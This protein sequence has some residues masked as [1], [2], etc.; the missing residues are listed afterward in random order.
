MQHDALRIGVIGVGGMGT[1]HART[2]AGLAGVELAAVADPYAPNVER[3]VAEFGCA[4]SSD[5]MALATDASLDAV[6]IASPDETHPELA[7]AAL[8]AGQWVL[9]E[10]PLATNL[11]DARRV[12]D[13]EI[14]VGSRRI[15]MGFMREYDPAHVQLRAALGEMGRLDAWRSI[16]RNCNAAPRPV[17]QIV[18]QSL[19]HDFHSVHFVTGSRIV[20]VHGFGGRP[21]GDSYRHIAVVCR[22]DSGLQAIVEFD[23]CGFA[24]E[25]LV[26]VL[27]EH[28]DAATGAPLRAV[29]RRNGAVETIIGPDWF[30]Y[31]AEA[32]RIQDAAWVASIRA[33]AATGPSAWD[34]VLAQAVVDSVLESFTS[35]VTTAVPQLDTPAIYTS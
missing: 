5:P 35:G 20:E 12:V 9:C 29:R 31:F 1:F 7:I 14:A 30:A 8:E 27:G 11:A 25:V 26:D 21:I 3:L 33:G 2:L 16:H 23:D 10:K 15:Q 18:G 32:Y 19:V 17:T 13:A 4:G 34:G 28:G 22:T 24:Y 6:V